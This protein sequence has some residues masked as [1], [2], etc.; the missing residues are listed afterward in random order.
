MTGGLLELKQ[1]NRVRGMM[2]VT[3]CG[4]DWGPGAPALATESLSGGLARDIPHTELKIRHGH[5]V[6]E[7]MMH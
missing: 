4:G 7:W 1:G 3:A 2:D 6:L 5:A